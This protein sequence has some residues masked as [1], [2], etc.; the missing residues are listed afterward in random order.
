MGD[1]VFLAL[2]PRRLR[3]RIGIGA[4]GNDL[5]DGV[6]ETRPDVRDPATAARV[7]SDIVQK[8]TDRFR[9]IGAVFECDAGDPEQVSEIGFA[10]PLLSSNWIAPRKAPGHFRNDGVGGSNPSCGTISWI[11]RKAS[12]PFC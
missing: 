4:A 9:F 1:V 12:G 2:A 3:D 11:K 10:R 7:L 8:R 6:A 5:G